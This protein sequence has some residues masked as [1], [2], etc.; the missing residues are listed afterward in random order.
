MWALWR[1]LFSREYRKQVGVSSRRYF[2]GYGTGLI[3][4][5]PP[6]ATAP[7]GVV[8]V[9]TSGAASQDVLAVN[10]AQQ[11]AGAQG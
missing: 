1:I 11:I 7:G 5:P 10:A 4:P 9:A 2:Q 3:Q 6:R 8:M